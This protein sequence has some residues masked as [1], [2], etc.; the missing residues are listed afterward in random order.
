MMVA[1]L[2]VVIVAE[3][4]LIIAIVKNVFA[5]KTLNNKSPMDLCTIGYEL[6]I[7]FTA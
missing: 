6:L 3:Y 5:L 7:S 1:I 4:M 2:M